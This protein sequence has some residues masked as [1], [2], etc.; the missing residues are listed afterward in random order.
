VIDFAIEDGG[1]IDDRISAGGGEGKGQC[2]LEVHWDGDE[3]GRSARPRTAWVAHKERFGPRPRGLGQ[4]AGLLRLEHSDDGWGV[5]K[6]EQ[7]GLFDLY[8][9]IPQPR[10]IGC[11]RLCWA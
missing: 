3:P 10:A 2:Q 5:V 4:K 6:K 8:Q 9:A 1:L 7:Q 11:W